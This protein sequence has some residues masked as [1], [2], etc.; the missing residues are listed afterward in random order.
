MN[1]LKDILINKYL[2]AFD[3]VKKDFLHSRPFTQEE[4]AG[5]F[6]YSFPNPLVEFGKMISLIQNNNPTQQDSYFYTKVYDLIQKGE[7]I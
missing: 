5:Y 6:L 4:T 2:N 7:N 1:N 3:E